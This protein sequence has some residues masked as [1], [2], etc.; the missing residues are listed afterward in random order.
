M[1]VRSGAQN[2]VF[3][4]FKPG[5]LKF[6]LHAQP[7]GSGVRKILAIAI[8]RFIKAPGNSQRAFLAL[9]QGLQAEFTSAVCW[10]L[11]AITEQVHYK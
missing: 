1:G 11:G 7:C 6:R 3:G 4:I 2:F 9:G 8:T 10:P 5:V